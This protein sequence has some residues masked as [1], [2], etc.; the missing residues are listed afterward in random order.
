[1]KYSLTPSVSYDGTYA[2]FM[3]QTTLFNDRK[4][5]TRLGVKW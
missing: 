1:M 5:Y 2:T 4:I 3:L